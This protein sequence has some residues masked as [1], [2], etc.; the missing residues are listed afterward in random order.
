[1]KAESI[2]ARN[3]KQFEKGLAKKGIALQ[4]KYAGNTDK[5]QG[6]SFIKGAFTF[7]GSEL[8]RSMGF[9]KLDNLF[10]VNSGINTALEKGWIDK[11]LSLSLI[12]RLKESIDSNT[13]EDGLLHALL[14]SEMVIEPDP[15]PFWLRKRTNN[16]GQDQGISR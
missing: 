10:Q 1:M 11:E 12:D 8:D 2:K 7:K 15:I 6:I 4:F 16:Q 13:Y 5:V 9:S 3:W 14:R